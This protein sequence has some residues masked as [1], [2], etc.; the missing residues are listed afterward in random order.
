MTDGLKYLMLFLEHGTIVT[1]VFDASKKNLGSLL[2][3][4]ILTGRGGGSQDL[5]P[6]FFKATK[7]V[8]LDPM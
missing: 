1:F 4:P 3:N 6:T 8:F 7:N 2:V 5:H